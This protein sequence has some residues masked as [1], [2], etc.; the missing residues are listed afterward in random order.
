M[1]GDARLARLLDVG[2]ASCAG[3]SCYSELSVQVVQAQTTGISDDA[4]ISPFHGLFP[5][6]AQ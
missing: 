5:D 3:K 4:Q 2:G 1:L 6:L